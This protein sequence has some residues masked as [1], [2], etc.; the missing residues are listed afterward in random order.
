MSNIIERRSKL[1]AGLPFSIK[2]LMGKRWDAMS[3]EDDMS[4]KQLYFKST[5]LWL[6]WLML[7]LQEDTWAVS[8]ITGR[9]YTPEPSVLEQLIDIDSKIRLLLPAEEFLSVQSSY[10]SFS[11]S[12]VC[13]QWHRSINFYVM[14]QITISNTEGCHRRC[15]EVLW[16]GQHSGELMAISCKKLSLLH[17]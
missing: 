8:V 11:I 16:Q 1:T 14:L 9:G 5:G 3:L 7:F 4:V 2:R 13:I 12:R 6:I 10:T 15:N 17:L